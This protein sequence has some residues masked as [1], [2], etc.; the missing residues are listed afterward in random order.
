[1]AKRRFRAEAWTVTD[2][3]GNPD[4]NA[5]H[6]TIFFLGNGRLGLRGTPEEG[7]GDAPSQPVNYVAPI[8]DLVQAGCDPRVGHVTHCSVS[9][10][11]ANWYGLVLHLGGVRFDPQRGT[12]SDYA[13]TLDLRTG[14]LI[15]RLTWTDDRGRRTALRFER[16]VSMADR[17]LAAL[18]VSIQ[19]LNWSGRARLVA[20][21]DGAAADRQRVTARGAIAP[22]GAYLATRT[23]ET[24]FETVT[25]I[26]TLAM[27]DDETVRLRPKLTRTANRV[28]R[29]LRFDLQAKETVRVEK[30]VAVCTSRDPEPEAPKARA[31]AAAAQARA[32]GFDALYADHVAA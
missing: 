14:L 27:H 20:D 29:E 31:V 6:E 2:R 26:R 8:W 19:P 16:F 23:R 11:A 21:I 25:A 18:R 5:F 1:M 17:R 4:Q 15:R 3:S 24:E 30:L 32:Q 10:A 13:R 9:V 22:D 7:A 28:A 12:V